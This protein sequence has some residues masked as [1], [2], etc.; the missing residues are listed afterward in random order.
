VPFNTAQDLA[1]DTTRIRAELG[2]REVVGPDDAL[3]QTVAWER[4]R[5]PEVPVDYPQEDGLLAELSYKR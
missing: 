1:V 5:L 2:Y 4:D 3:R